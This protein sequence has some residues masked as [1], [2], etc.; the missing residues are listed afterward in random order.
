MSLIPRHYIES[1][2]S[3]GIRLSN[4]YIDWKGT[5][6]FVV[7]EVVK[8][9][10]QYFLIT[11]RHV[12][13]KIFCIVIR[14]R[15]KDTGNLRILDLPLSDGCTWIYSKHPD[16][17]VDIAAISITDGYIKENNLN[18]SAFNL[19]DQALKSNDFIEQGGAEGSPVYMLGFPLGLKI[20]DFEAP[21]CRMGCIARINSLEIKKNKIFLLNIQ[22]ISG[23]S[24]SPIIS[25]P[26][27]ISVE[28]TK[29]FDK[30]V[31]IGIVFA[32]ATY[33]EQVISPE[34]KE[35]VGILAENSGIA[36]AYPVEYI[37]DTVDMEIKN[38]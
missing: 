20:D 13:E 5:G 24:G 31:L 1:V 6:F 33:G 12:L 23:H 22:N 32:Y 4:N 27:A 26:E 34:T 30:S 37:R 8:G 16:P 28:G 2:V 18:L 21:V 36:F 25:Q 29:A 9:K 17:T 14:L 35:T 19:D 10:F 11:N 38:H 7:K 15:E 3:I